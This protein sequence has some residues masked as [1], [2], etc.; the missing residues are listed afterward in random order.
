MTPKF[1]EVTK[2]VVG[3]PSEKVMVNPRRVDFFKPDTA[4]KPD[5]PA[6]LYFGRGD[7]LC[8]MESVSQIKTL[9]S[10]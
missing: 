9:L 6:I 8:V 2:R 1:I 10:K 3:L 4:T 5:G 7:Y